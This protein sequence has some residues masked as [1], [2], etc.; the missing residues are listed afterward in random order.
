MHYNPAEWY[1][2]EKFLPE[3]FDPE[4]K[5]FLSPSTGKRRDTYS[6]I[7]F[8]IGLR[9]CPGQTLAKLVQK[10]ALPYF[11]ANLEYEVD[12]DLLNNDKSLFNNSSQFHLMIDIKSNRLLSD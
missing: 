6:Y 4:S 5:Y 1:E 7:P 11:L 10:I 3:R 2:P 8:L 12:K 9:S